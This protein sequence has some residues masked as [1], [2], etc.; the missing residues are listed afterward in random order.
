MSILFLTLLGKATY[1]LITMNYP[2]DTFSWF[3]NPDFTINQDTLIKR[4]N[5]LKNAI[6]QNKAFDIDNVFN[7]NDHLKQEKL[8]V[9]NL[10]KEDQFSVFAMNNPIPKDLFGNDTKTVDIAKQTNM[11]GTKGEGTAG[12]VANFGMGAIDMFGSTSSSDGDAIGKGLDM[13]MKGAQAGMAVGGPVGAGVGAGIG[14]AIGIYDGFADGNK[15]DH[16]ERHK[17]KMAQE[18][19]HT[20]LEQQQRQ[21]DGLDSLTRLSELRKTE[22]RYIL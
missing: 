3:E 8:Q 5:L 21:K 13:T 16:M 15:R 6:T 1:N 12:A 17:N 7:L 22:E 18:K 9:P 10:T 20:E 19:D 4:N 11:F 14:A 2:D